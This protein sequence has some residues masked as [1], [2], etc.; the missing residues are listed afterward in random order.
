M[1]DF[2]DGE[3]EFQTGEGFCSWVLMAGLDGT[4][5]LAETCPLS[6]PQ[7]ANTPL[8][9]DSVPPGAGGGGGRRGQAVAV[10]GGW[11]EAAVFRYTTICQTPILRQAQRTRRLANL[12]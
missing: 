9:P 2:V 4:P 1:P 5:R 6:I 8:K 12:V 7:F 3:T 10:A 11:A